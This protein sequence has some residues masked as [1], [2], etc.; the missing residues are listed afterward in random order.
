MN[1]RKIVFTALAILGAVIVLAAATF[2]YVVW[3]P[4]SP[5]R[6][7]ENVDI[8]VRW[9]TPFA[10][11]ADELH[12]M[13]VVRSV[14]QLK[15]TAAVFKQTQKLRVGKFSLK[16][17]MSNYAALKALIEGPQ[18]TITVTLPNGYDSRRFAQ[19]IERR[20]EVD[21]A[22]IMA[23]VA[24]TAFIRELGVDAPTLEGFLYPETYKFTY[25]L[26]A[27]QI[28]RTLVRQFQKT[29]PDSLFDV[30][31]QKGWSIINV[32]TL[33]S[34]IEGEAMIDEEMPII[35]SVYHNRL[36]KGML[37]Q[38]DP[39]IQY[40]ITDGPRRLLRRDL[41]IDS[42][43]NTYLYKG[44]PP[45]PISNPGIKA[46]RAAVYPAQTAYLYFVANG[47]GTHTFSR[48]FNQHLQ[49]KKRFDRV[50]R[51][52]EREKRQKERNER[53]KESTTY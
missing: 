41:K 53:N 49:A 34:I 9:G 30:A 6:D 8:I 23:L 31:A 44:L 7:A 21:S 25:G 39:T 38:A 27:R 11:V 50:R 35:S 15:F 24:D 1:V 12:Q 10:R 17:G 45:G 40:I 43:Y 2:S 3:L 48:S 37:L 51:Q 47:D 14:E 5:P 13:G 18:S 29:V 42:P 36:K 16:R 20:L 22:K 46:I 33:A 28:V 19:I 32:L 4:I 26:E 52:V